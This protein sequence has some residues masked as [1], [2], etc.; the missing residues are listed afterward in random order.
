[1]QK[2]DYKPD[3]EFDAEDEFYSS[4]IKYKNA[5]GFDKYSESHLPNAKAY[6]A[7]LVAM[8]RDV[9]NSKRHLEIFKDQ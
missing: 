5:G 1:M 3:L 6:Q 4:Y 8:R 2:I 7:L 9:T